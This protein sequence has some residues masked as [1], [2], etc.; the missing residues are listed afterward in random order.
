MN[1]ALF[2][3]FMT[4]ITFMTF[5]LT[6][7]TPSAFDSRLRFLK[8]RIPL[9]PERVDRRFSDPG[10]PGWKIVCN[11]LLTWIEGEYQAKNAIRDWI[12]SALR[13]ARAQLLRLERSAHE[14]C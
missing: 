1:V 6:R 11:A 4:F 14:T 7:A 5:M 10:W 13:K 9:P 2:H 3:M 8:E 12:F